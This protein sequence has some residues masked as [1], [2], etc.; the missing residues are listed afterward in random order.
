[1]ARKAADFLDAT[2]SG[3]SPEA[4]RSSVCPSHYMGLVEL[5]RETH[6]PHYLALAKKF[7]ELRGQIKDGGDDNQDR[8]PFGQQTNAMGHAVRGNYLYAG[9]ADLFVETGDKSLWKPLEPIWRN[10][11][12]QKMYIT[13]GCGALYDGASPDGSRWVSGWATLYSRVGKSFTKR[14]ISSTISK[15]KE[16]ES[17]R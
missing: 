9:A 12:E 6:E 10:L 3:A 2:M 17:A 13:G 4:A 7:F 5:Y 11:T 8:I 1:V 15:Q 16:H 14:K